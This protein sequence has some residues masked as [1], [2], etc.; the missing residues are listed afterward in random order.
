[1]TVHWPLSA[2]LLQFVSVYHREK[3]RCINVVPVKNHHNQKALIY[4]FPMKVRSEL[5][6][7]LLPI[8]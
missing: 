2:T 6:I 1:M 8:Y 5:N 4:S 3:G 7:T